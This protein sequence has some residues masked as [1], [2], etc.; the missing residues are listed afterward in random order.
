MSIEVRQMQINATMSLKD[1]STDNVVSYPESDEMK[2]EFVD[3][4]ESILREC[5]SLIISLLENERER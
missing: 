3:M 5:H 2:R 4:K 1:D